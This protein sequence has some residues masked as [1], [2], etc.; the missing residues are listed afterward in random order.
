MNKNALIE[1]IDHQ[2]A[3]LN[4]ERLTLHTS[5]RKSEIDGATDALLWVRRCA[6]RG[7]V[8]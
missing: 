2:I 7:I 6:L 3:L 5:T 8:V 4:S 1:A